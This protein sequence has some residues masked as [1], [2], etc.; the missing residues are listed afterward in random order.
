MHHDDGE[1][2]FSLE[3]PQECQE[4]RHISRMVLV[5]AMKP[6]QG[7]ENEQARARPP[8]GFVE[9][10][11]VTIEIE[12]QARGGDDVE[13]DALK[14]DPTVPTEPLEALADE[15]GMI[16]G[17]IDEHIAGLRDLESVETGRAGRDG[18]REIESQPRL[19]ELGVAR[20]ESDSCPA[21]ELVDEPA[22]VI[23][24]LV[25]LAHATDR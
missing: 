21:P 25:E 6:H 24:G 23:L 8:D 15:G 18:E 1:I 5:S 17:E 20:C 11:S 2:V 16:L 7:I 14:I 10:R 13:G 3:L 9:P 22:G 12:A 4:L 19:P